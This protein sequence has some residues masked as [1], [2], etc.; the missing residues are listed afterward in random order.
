MRQITRRVGRLFE[1]NRPQMMDLHAFIEHL[2]P[3][4][5]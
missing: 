3:G 4:L 2:R 1:W 5:M